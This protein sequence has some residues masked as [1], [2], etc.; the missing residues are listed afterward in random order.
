MAGAGAAALLACSRGEVGGL[1]LDDSATARQPGTVWF[2]KN[3]WRLADETKE[4]IRGGIYRG[5]ASADAPSHLDPMPNTSSGRPTTIHTHEMLMARNRGP[6]VEPGSAAYNNPVGSLAESWE[7]SDDGATVTFSLR[8]GV[9]FHDLPPVNGRVM[10]LDDWRTSHDRHLEVG[11]YRLAIGDALDRAEYPDARHMVWRF[12]EPFAPLVDRIWENQFGYFILP[13]ELNANPSTAERTSIGT[14][15]KILDKYEPAVG[16]QYRKNPA[17]WGGD[18]FIDRWSYPIIPE[19]ANAYAQ[20][21]RGN[22]I[23]FLPTARDVTLLRQDAPDAVI[24]ADLLDENKI[25]VHKWGKEWPGTAWG[26]ERVRI[27]MRRSVDY[28]GIAEFL[29][30][31]ATF[32]SAG[33]PIEIGIMTHMSRQ[34]AYWLDPEKGELGAYS[35]NY[36]YNPAEARKLTSAAGYNDPIVL[37]YHVSGTGDI[38]TENQLVIDSLMNSGVFKI[39]VKQIPAAEY[40]TNINVNRA[41][42]GTQSPNSGEGNFDYLW[43]NDYWSGRLGGT[44]F[45]DTM[46]DS[47]LVAQRREMDFERRGAL[48]KE[49]Q[50]YL[51]QKFYVNPALHQFTTFSIRW[52]W[53]HNSNYGP[54]YPD[55]GGHLQWLDKD[56]PDRNRLI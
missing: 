43:F 37:P 50:L 46:L 41:Y 44:T 22:I 8:Q 14:G 30:D 18:P 39:D 40:R 36:L 49:L 45:P 21:I 10:D 9:K 5:R 29:S 19:Y 25:S 48:V 32:E 27:A 54:S 33:I 2:S 56:M 3:D 35:D 20:F 16:F 38:A 28:P 4:A 31:R 1:K 47:L 23:D 12:K 13:K 51:A 6:G 15:F 55:V 17:Y 11:V 52:P 34:P 24:V 42:S 26:D 53:V 7:I